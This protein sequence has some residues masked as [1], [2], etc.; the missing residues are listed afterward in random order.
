MDWVL[1]VLIYKRLSAKHIHCYHWKSYRKLNYFNRMLS[2]NQNW[3]L[4]AEKSI[5][6]FYIYFLG[7]LIYFFALVYF[8]EKFIGFK[9]ITQRNFYV[10]IWYLLWNKWIIFE[11]L[12][13]I[14]HERFIKTHNLTDDSSD[15]S[16]QFFKNNFLKT[17]H[18]LHKQLKMLQV[19]VKVN[20]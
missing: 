13:V 10:I 2:K 1:K 20:L 7:P 6:F 11:F 8:K 5:L 18:V 17:N 19:D 16:L 9:E 4:S 14:I 3:T 12:V 15:Y